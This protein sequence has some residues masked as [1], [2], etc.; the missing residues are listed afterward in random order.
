VFPVL[1]NNQGEVRVPLP[2]PN[3]R[4]LAG[5][6]VFSQFLAPSPCAPQGW[7]ASHGLAV[8]VQR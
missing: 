7:S 1:A 5:V 3:D 4:S 6:T 8:T 2:I